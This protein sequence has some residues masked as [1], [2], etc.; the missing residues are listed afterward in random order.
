MEF[1]LQAAPIGVGLEPRP[2]LLN[3]SREGPLCEQMWELPEV[4]TRSEEEE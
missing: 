1:R 2:A 3:Y 4:R